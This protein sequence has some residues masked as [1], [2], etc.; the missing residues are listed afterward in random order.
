MRLDYQSC[1]ESLDYY[2]KN[3]REVFDTDPEKA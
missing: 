1:L 2:I 3:Y